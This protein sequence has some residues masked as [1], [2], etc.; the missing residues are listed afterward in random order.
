MGNP[1]Q[2]KARKRFGQHFLHDKNIIHKLLRTINL[3]PGDTVIEIGPG[4]GALT[5]PL[6]EQCKELTAIELDRDLIPILQQGAEN[7]GEL[8]LINSDI[9]QIDMAALSLEPPFRLV[10]N[11]PY[12]IS[13]PLMFHMLEYNKLIKDM[14][15]MVQKEV[16]ERIIATSDKNTSS[17]KHYGRLSVMMQ[18][19]C[20]CQYL[21]DVPPGCF[22][23]PP[24]VDSAIIRLIPHASP[25]TQVSDLEMLEA[26]VKAA[27]NQRRKTVSNSLKK[28]LSRDQILSV[29][30]NPGSRAENL[31]LAD[32]SKLS[33]LASN[34]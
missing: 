30:I 13:T 8:K 26:V 5:F 15:F 23:P 16:A 21:F 25:P 7:I 33:N 34:V 14:H 20:Q 3:Q 29:D 6:L 2:H 4:Q 9:L 32:F 1:A 27:F 10:G 17:S 28:L 11:L 19:F 12:N 18:Y 31:S 22:S 24:K